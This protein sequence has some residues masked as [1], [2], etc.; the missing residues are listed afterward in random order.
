MNYLSKFIPY[1]S[2]FR[3]LLQELLK[4]ENEFCWMPV[5]DEAFKNLKS[6]I[7][8]DMMQKY[9]DTN[10]L[11]YIETDASKKGIGVALMQPD[12]NVQNTSKTAVPNNLRPVYYVSKMLTVT[13]SNYSNIEREMLGVVFS[14]LHFKYFTYGHSITVITDHKPL[15]TLFKKNITASSPRLSRMLIKI[16]DFQIDLQHQEGSKIHLSDA[17]SRFNTHDSDNARNSSVPIADFNMSIHEIE[18]ITGFKPI[19][20]K[21]IQ[22]TTASDTQLMQLKDCI[23]D[24][25]CK[26]KHE[27]TELVR[28]FYD[29]R[30]LLCII[31]GLILKDK[32][33]AIPAG[34]RDDAMATLH[35][36]HMGIVKT[37]EHASTCMFWPRMY[38]DIEKFLS[39][40]R[41][42][43][44][45]KFKQSPE[46]LE[47]DIPT[48]PWHSLTLDN[49]EYRGT[50]Y[51][52][53][54]D[55]FPG[56]IVVKNPS[57]LSA[58][59]TIRCLLLVFCEHGVPSFIHTDRGRNFISREFSQFCQDLSI[60]L[61]FS[62]G[63]HHSANQAE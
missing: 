5:H 10:L 50:L 43:M 35:R 24:S 20:I 25:F 61:N 48:S 53:I 39:S 49:F 23:I 12:L 55:R 46:P 34:L 31:N 30:E 36:S 29:Y 45:H 11:I 56:F 7:V 16:I 42:C 18:H 3:Q 32:C 17:I 58:K 52:I 62:S 40:C 9:F 51:L 37:K 33:I 8:K 44:T 54:Y 38:S 6:A 1:L 59:S 57:D 47:H 2:D 22:D 63:Y 60:H 4:K 21:E 14:V 13:E 28:D 15:I 19:T 41:P 26:S 27:C